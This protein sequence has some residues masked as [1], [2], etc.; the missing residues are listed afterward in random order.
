[1]V[2][3]VAGSYEPVCQIP[4]PPVFH[5]LLLSFHVS[6]PGSPGLGTTYHR[7]NSFPV[8]AS[9]AATQPR[10][11]ASPAPFAMMTLS[12]AVIGAV[13]N[14]SLLPNSLAVATI[15]SQTISPLSRLIAITRPSG[16]LARTRSSHNATP[17]VRGALPWCFTPGSVT[18]TN[19]P[20]FGSRASIL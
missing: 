15:L 6:L 18:H 20:L 3:R 13:T 14:F 8:L 16:R 2:R 1:M 7:H 9:S 4:P 5:E 12:S 19:D 11:P 10:V 17:R